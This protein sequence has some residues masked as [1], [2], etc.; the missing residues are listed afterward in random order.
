MCR[1]PKAA[2]PPQGVVQLLTAQFT[3]AVAAALLAAACWRH[4]TVV[5]SLKAVEVTM[6]AH[7]VSFS[8]AVTWAQQLCFSHAAQAES[9]AAAGQEPPLVVP[10]HSEL[11][12][13][14]TQVSRL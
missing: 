3:N 12:L 4:S 14:S 6:L 11:Q 10:L 8:H 7:V 2:Q 9:P 5:Q 1:P 13:P